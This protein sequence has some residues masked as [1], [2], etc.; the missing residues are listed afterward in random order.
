MIRPRVLSLAAAIALLTASLRGADETFPVIHNEPITVRIVGGI[1]GM[2]LSNLHLVLVSGYDQNDLHNQLYREDVLTDAFGN[3]RLPK[4]L[5]NLPWLQVWIGSMPLCQ[6]KPRQASFSV[7]LIRRDGLSAPNLCGAVSAQN[8]P[9]VFTV[10]VKN[11]AEKLHKGVSISVGLPLTQS[12]IP[13]QPANSTAEATLA[14][15]SLAAA[16]ETVVSDVAP[17]EAPVEAAPKASSITQDAAPAPVISPTS[18]SV[19][20]PI[21]TVVHLQSRRVAVRPALHRSRSLPAACSAQPPAEDRRRAAQPR[22]TPTS[23]AHRS[24]PLAGVRVAAEKPARPAAS[25]KRE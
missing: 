12:P 15:V 17:V 14:I 1:N 6:S 24:K 20:V 13:T 18:A 9:G 4:Q 7:E 3:A 2:P 10:F 16:P 19:I 22:K 5:A 21:K 23:A 8:T 25:E 11:K